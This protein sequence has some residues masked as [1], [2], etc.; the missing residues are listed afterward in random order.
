M[1]PMLGM[2][3][4]SCYPLSCTSHRTY[5][6]STC[7]RLTHTHCTLLPWTRIYYGTDPWAIGAFNHYKTC[8]LLACCTAAMST[9]M[10]SCRLA[11]LANVEPVLHADCNAVTLYDDIQEPVIVL[12]LV[13]DPLFQK[14]V[15]LDAHP[16]PAAQ[17]LLYHEV[18]PTQ[19]ALRPDPPQP[20]DNIQTNT[21]KGCCVH[22][23]S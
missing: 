2:V 12:P 22:T 17:P 3:N 4:A 8:N 9:L 14:D 23:P 16:A 21:G 11:R 10:L 18:M 15:H 7:P 20:T 1:G 5:L 19:P 6:S 13:D